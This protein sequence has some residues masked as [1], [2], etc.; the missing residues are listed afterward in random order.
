MGAKLQS[1]TPRNVWDRLTVEELE[2]LGREG[3]EIPLDQVRVLDDG[4]LAYK[5]QR[6]VL[7]I[8]DVK[9]YRHSEPSEQDLPRFHVAD[10]DKLQ[11]MRANNRYE[12]YV[13]A[14]RDTGLFTI[15][16]KAQGSQRYVQSD[17][18]LSVCQYCLGRLDWDGFSRFRYQRDRNRSRNQRREIVSLFSLERYFAKFGK[19]FIGAM[20]PHTE[21][22]APLNDYNEDF[23][24]VAERIKRKRGYCCD[25]CRV[26]LENHRRFLHAHH[27]NG[28][29]SDDR[30]DNIAIL[31]ILHH[32]EQPNHDHMKQLPE[33]REFCRLFDAGAFA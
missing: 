14:T 25:N 28:I 31:C 13:V 11:E 26:N 33:Y 29:Q 20:P 23:A 6:V 4:T 21:E 15:N 8:R 17:R 30:D 24:K 19:T 10:C 16:L 5:N 32:A 1:F 3:I 22:T 18:R 2:R 7:Y 9:Q 27:K 12:R